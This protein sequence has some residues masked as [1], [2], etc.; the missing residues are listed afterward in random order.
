MKIS[1]LINNLQ[2][3]LEENGDLEAWYAS[4]DEGNGFY[5]VFCEPSVL[6]E[7]EDGELESPVCCIN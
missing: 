6:T 2:T 3:F 5:P 4:D 1:E 7:Y